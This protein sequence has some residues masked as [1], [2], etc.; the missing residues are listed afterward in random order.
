MSDDFWQ[1]GCS[2]Q[3]PSALGFLSL[4]LPGLQ[5]WYD[6]FCVVDVL[7]TVLAERHAGQSSLPPHILREGKVGGCTFQIMVFELLAV[8]WVEVEDRWHSGDGGTLRLV[9][10]F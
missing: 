8:P 10:G 3:N 6:V 1:E 9:F 4:D 2:I 7:K 5:R